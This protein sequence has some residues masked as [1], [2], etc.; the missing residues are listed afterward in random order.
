MRGPARRGE[1]LSGVP[2]VFPL[3]SS[4]GCCFP[5]PS[6]LLFFRGGTGWEEGDE[7]GETTVDGAADPNRP[8]EREGPLLRTPSVTCLSSSSSEKLNEG[9]TCWSAFRGAEDDVRERETAFGFP[10]RGPFPQALFFSFFKPGFVPWFRSVSSSED[11]ASQENERMFFRL[12]LSFCSPSAGLPWFLWFFFVFP[13]PSTSS[14]SPADA[15]ED[16][17]EEEKEKEAEIRFFLAFPFFSLFFFSL[18]SER[19]VLFE[20]LSLTFGF[21]VFSSHERPLRSDSSRF[22]ETWEVGFP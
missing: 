4:F 12:R 7:T 9:L 10:L 21:R 18:F 11:S 2:V 8:V 22:V 1:L 20:R 6:V 15:S 3:F 14:S 5:S 19:D 16:E 17:E 13:L